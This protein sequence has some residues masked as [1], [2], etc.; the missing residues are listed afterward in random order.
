LLFYIIN[1][2]SKINNLKPSFVKIIT[3]NSNIL[4]EHEKFLQLN[5]FKLLKTYKQMILKNDKLAPIK[6]DFIQKPSLNDLEE[7]Y[8][9]L[10]N[11]FKYE[12][13]LFYNKKKF[14]DYIENI[15]IYKENNRICGILLY[16]NI[17]SYHSQLEYIAIKNSLN[18]KNVAYALLNSFFLE[19]QNKNFYKLFV[20]IE[21]TKAINFYKKSNFIFKEVELRLYR[22]FL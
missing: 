5:D 17:I 4:E 19:N 7:C 6:F 21:N 12:F 16:D 20:D 9:F 1:N 8:N 2:T 13:E 22:N 3:K 18:Y 11:I 10:I 14:K 15:L